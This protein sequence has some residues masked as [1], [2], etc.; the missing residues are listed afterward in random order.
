MLQLIKND[1]EDTL[2]T[3]LPNPPIEHYQTHRIVGETYLHL[4]ST[5]QPIHSTLSNAVKQQ[6]HQALKLIQALTEVHA[7]LSPHMPL[8][9]IKGPTLSQLIYQDPCVRTAKDIDLLVLKE[10]LARAHELIEQLGYVRISP[11]RPLSGKTLDVAIDFGKDFKYLHPESGVCIE[12]HYQ[13]FINPKLLTI[14]QKTLWQ[15]TTSVTIGQT[16]YPTLSPAIY[17]LYLCTH[18]LYSGYSRLHWL[19]DVQAFIDSVTFDH[20][21]CLALAEQ[22]Q[23][24]H[25]IGASLLLTKDKLNSHTPATFTD[26]LKD[27][28]SIVLYNHS[29][30]FLENYHTRPDMIKN[31]RLRYQSFLMHRT[32][33]YRLNWYRYEFYSNDLF[34]KC[35]TLTRIKGLYH[36]IKPFYFAY[37]LLRALMPL[38]QLRSK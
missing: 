22:H 25:I 37:R 7:A 18:G 23:L 1:T 12:C 26:T 31:V 13:L 28:Q 19:Y 5:Q 15:N 32:L 36:V 21:A 10:D 30:T 4:M 27:K 20:Q 2:Q 9:H 11:S 33:S 3:T 8:L 29:K 24:T 16:V 6:R 14:A 38:R 34:V 35:P 17:F